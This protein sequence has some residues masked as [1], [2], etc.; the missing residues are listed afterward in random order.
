VVSRCSPV[1][2]AMNVKKPQ[3]GFKVLVI[4]EFVVVSWR[5]V[6]KKR[7]CVASNG[8]ALV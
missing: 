3:M 2:Y 5:L 8:L 4:G 1:G 6:I 7:S